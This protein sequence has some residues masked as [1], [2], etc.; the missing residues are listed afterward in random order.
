MRQSD[1]QPVEVPMQVARAVALVMFAITVLGCST[2]DE[3][4]RPAAQEPEPT[5]TTP[6]PDG[7][8]GSLTTLPSDQ[9]DLEG[10]LLEI[11]DRRNEDC[12]SQAW[13]SGIGRPAMAEIADSRSTCDS[14]VLLRHR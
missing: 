10:R 1:I 2:G 12:K 9:V 3:Q 11:E 14:V 5:P 4:P 8:S 6:E 13:R 7:A